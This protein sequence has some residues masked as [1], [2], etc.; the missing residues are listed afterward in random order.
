MKRL[1][2]NPARTAAALPRTLIDALDP[3]DPVR[4]ESLVAEHLDKGGIDVIGVRTVA[5]ITE[6]LLAIA[7]DAK[8]KPLPQATAAMI[9]AYLE[10]AAPAPQVPARVRDLV[11]K[12]GPGLESAIAAFER[13][14]APD[15]T[16][17]LGP[18]SWP[19]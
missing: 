5:E 18:T 16:A 11:G 6:G 17:G 1:T 9:E 12:A 4:A 7:A 3:T 2:S 15:F 19:P 10:L 14:S 8:A 13:R